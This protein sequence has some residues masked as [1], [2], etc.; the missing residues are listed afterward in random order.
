MPTNRIQVEWTENDGLEAKVYDNDGT[1]HDITAIFQKVSGSLGVGIV[2]GK[3]ELGNGTTETKIDFRPTARE[4]SFD[5][6][7]KVVDQILE[8]LP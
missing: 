8:A 5:T 1:P 6:S 4:L 2:D 3:I 7:Q